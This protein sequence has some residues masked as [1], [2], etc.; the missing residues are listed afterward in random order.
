MIR[1]IRRGTGRKAD[2]APVEGIRKTLSYSGCQEVCSLPI[3]IN[4]LQLAWRPTIFRAW[5]EKQWLTSK[6]IAAC[7]SI[8][9]GSKLLNNLSKSSSDR[10]LA[11][12]YIAIRRPGHSKATKHWKSTGYW[13]VISVMSSNWWPHFS[14]VTLSRVYSTLTDPYVFFLASIPPSGIIFMASPKLNCVLL[15]GGRFISTAW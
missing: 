2:L 8:Q 6:R 14:I 12:Q 10:G 15:T 1:P 13:Q 7:W 4:Q 5:R 11:E 3:L 9:E